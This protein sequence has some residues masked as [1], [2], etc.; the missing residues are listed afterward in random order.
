MCKGVFHIDNFQRSVTIPHRRKKQT[1]QEVP[2]AQH[3]AAALPYLLRGAETFHSS[4]PASHDFKKCTHRES[5]SLNLTKS[6]NFFVSRNVD[7]G[8]G[9]WSSSHI[10][11][12]FCLTSLV[13]GSLPWLLLSTQE[14]KGFV[15]ITY[16]LSTS[17]KGKTVVNLRLSCL[18]HC[19]PSHSTQKHHT[20]WHWCLPSSAPFYKDRMRYW[21]HRKCLLIICNAKSNT[22]I[23]FKS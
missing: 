2:K 23:Q 15:S 3:C 13:G 17:F 22:L 10:F 19:L 20:T 12:D 21:N 5:G 1:W 4:S 7:L 18:Y 8:S 14:H 16:W 6:Q 9:F 11:L